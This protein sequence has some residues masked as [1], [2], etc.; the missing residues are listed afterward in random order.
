MP[1]LAAPFVGSVLGVLILRLPAGRPVVLARSACED[2]GAA[3][4]PQDLVPLLSYA[5]LRGRCRRCGHPIGWFH[6]AVEL[7]ALAVA[8]WAGLAN[9]Y[10][11]WANCVLGWGLL[12]LAWIDWGHMRLP[13]VLTLPLIPAGLLV[14]WQV[15]P[16]LAA[17]HGAAAV[18]AYLLFRGV[19]WA[20]R[21]VRGFDGLGQGD[22]KLLAVAGAWVGFAGLP[23]VLLGGGLIGLAVAVLHWRKAASGAPLPF[24]PALALALWTMRL[25]G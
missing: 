8:A 18:A 24:G 17:I 12:A 4:Q 3:L 5:A 10:E 1:L 11:V 13:D 2:C 20:Y 19:A 15:D 21:R 6:P 25:Y 23:G 22:A 9:P 7:A 14:A 16:E